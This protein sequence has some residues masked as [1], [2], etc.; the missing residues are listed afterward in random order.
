MVSSRPFIGAR[1]ER[2]YDRRVEASVRR[3]GWRDSVIAYTGYGNTDRLRVLARVIASP[4]SSR[5]A[6][7]LAAA[8]ARAWLERR[9]WRNFVAVPC[10]DRLVRITVGSR[11][12]EAYA[13]RGGYVDV[14]VDGHDLTPGWH[15]IAIETRQ[16]PPTPAPV[17]IIGPQVGFGIVSDI[18][19]TIL[20]TNVPRPLL[21]LWHSLIQTEAAREPVAGMAAL[22]HD[23]LGAHP[24]APVIYL[25]TGAWNTQPFLER[26]I[27]YHGFP[28]GP[29]LLTDW[30]P[31]QTGWQRSG[32]AHK[33]RSLRGLAR[34]F[35]GIR[36]LLVGDDGQRDPG[37]YAGFARIYPRHVAAIAIRELNPVQQ[38]LAHGT[39]TQL[40]SPG[41]VAPV[42]GIEV[43]GPDGNA[44]LP[45]VRRLLGDAD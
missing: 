44:L 45:Q 25:S 43:R 17:Q 39:F 14:T 11:V 26:F 6:E 19:D 20:T 22:Y 29:M 8:Q 18:D 12:V 9:G 4:A 1:L 30:G 34:D 33:A 28:P 5:A 32:P 37:I 35:P 27:A 24:D 2:A 40:P 13:D 3:L 16:C 21:S 31:T 41:H 10:V 42:P 15:A 38:I 7:R 23:L 36:W